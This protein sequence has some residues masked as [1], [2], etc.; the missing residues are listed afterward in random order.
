M[1]DRIVLIVAIIACLIVVWT[2]GYITA[3]HK[4][5]EKLSSYSN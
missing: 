1:F 4:A 5:I 2:N 3:T